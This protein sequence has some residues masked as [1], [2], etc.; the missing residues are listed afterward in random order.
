MPDSRGEGGRVVTY[1][2]AVLVDVLVYH[3][4][5]DIKG[6]GCGWS[7]LGASWPEHVADVYEQSVAAYDGMAD[8]VFPVEQLGVLRGRLSEIESLAEQQ[9]ADIE[10]LARHC[11]VQAHL[12]RRTVDYVEEL[13]R[14]PL[15]SSAEA[16]A[17]AVL[18]GLT[19]RPDGDR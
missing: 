15:D 6:C 13:L 17:K 1:D 3:Y 12:I 14:G 11:D 7:Q 2:R 16:I 10:R 19:A 9:H 18:A 5:D 4:R 8:V